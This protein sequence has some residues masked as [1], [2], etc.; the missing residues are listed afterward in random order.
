MFDNQPAQTSH[1][2][3]VANAMFNTGI[4]HPLLETSAYEFYIWDKSDNQL[5]R[6]G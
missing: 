5:Y 3:V 6:T 4:V 2:S 1:S